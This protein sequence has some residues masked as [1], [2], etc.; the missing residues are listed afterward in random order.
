MTVA[1]NTVIGTLPGGTEVV[2]ASLEAGRELLTTVDDH[3]SQQSPFDRQARVN[4][5]RQVV[6]VAALDGPKDQHARPYASSSSATRRSAFSSTAKAASSS[7][8]AATTFWQKG[9][10][11]PMT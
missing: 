1:S 10:A 4:L 11:S 9:H 8:T 3:L 5:R 2:A 6:E 7:P